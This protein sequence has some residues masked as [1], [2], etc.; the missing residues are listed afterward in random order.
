VKGKRFKIY[1]KKLNLLFI[2]VD[3]IWFRYIHMHLVY[4]IMFRFFIYMI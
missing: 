3:V 4:R 1:R 2:N